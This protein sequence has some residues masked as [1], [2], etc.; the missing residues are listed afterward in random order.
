MM[1]FP[2]PGVTFAMDFPI[3]PKKLFPLLDEL[4]QIVLKAGGR[5]YPAKDS[6]MSARTFQTGYPEWKSFSEYVDPMFSSSFWRRVTTST[7]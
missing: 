5:L 4:D 1:S 3:I 7:N 2:Q 6:R